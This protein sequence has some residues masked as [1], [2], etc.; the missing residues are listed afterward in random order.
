MPDET[1]TESDALAQYVENGGLL[2]RFAGPKL[3]KRPDALLP[4]PLRSG[5]REY[6]GAL[7]W[8]D[9]QKLA[10]F[11]EDSPFFGLKIPDDITVK[12]QVMAQPSAETDARTWARLED[13][14]P[15]VTSD[16]YGFGRIV[17]FHVT[18]GPEWSNLAI[19]G[20]YV[21]ML[22]RMLGMARASPSQ[23]T[24]GGGNWAP[25]RVLN[26][27]GRL[28]APDIAVKPIADEAF[29]A[30]EISAAHPPGL[31]RLGARR[32][33]LNT[34]KNPETFAMIG[35]LNGV[36]T[37]SYGQVQTQTLG[38]LL[39]GAALTLLA[40][41]ALFALY[42][43]GRFGYLKS[44]P[45]RRATVGMFAISIFAFPQFADA[46]DASADLEA[47]EL[48]LAYVETGDAR[49]DQM[50]EAAMS[51]LVDSLSRRTTIEPDGVKSIDLETDTLSF[52]PF[53]YWPVDRNAPA[54]SDNVVTK[55][56][57]YMAGGGTLVFD[58][59]DTADQSFLGGS[60]HPGLARITENLDIP[61]L[62][63]VPAD[64][65]LTKSFYLVQVFP[66]RWANGRVWVDRNSNGA[67]RDGV[68]SVII[69]SNDW[70]AGW[71]QDDDRIPLVS[72]EREIPNQREM[73]IRFGV[74]LAMYTLAG[75]YK[76]DQVHAAA[77]V[78]RLG[79]QQLQPRNLG[80]GGL[81]D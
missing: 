32:Q 67:A 56:N 15:I 21:D 41:D 14:S 30:T 60:P 78:E 16:Q 59:Q 66:G 71:A 55:L 5:G 28:T 4:V 39:L 12:Q 54:L 27:F 35:N 42:V 29:A 6:G 44:L 81:G 43:S 52:Y 33:A 23:T 1:R 75:N 20:L 53:L 72:L 38:G 70:A 76:S 62:T 74:N 34:I 22:R 64:H 49:T 25:E 17:L 73:S 69:G 8:E 47:L 48:H 50:S 36:K 77:L 9:P 7:T 18:A 46:Q 10:P 3:A 24:A 45:W 19:G 51:G 57:D 58:T 68:S 11:S 40:L 31:Y 13:G 65:V 80:P 26:G 63:E 2:I 79:R 37:A 61:S